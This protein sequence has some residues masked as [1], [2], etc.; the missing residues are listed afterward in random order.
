MLHIVSGIN[1]Q[2][3]NDEIERASEKAIENERFS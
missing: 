3:I 2:S 1:N